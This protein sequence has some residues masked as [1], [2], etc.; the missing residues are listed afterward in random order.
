MAGSLLYL[1]TTR[2]VFLMQQRHYLVATIPWFVKYFCLV[3]LKA[4]LNSVYASECISHDSRKCT[5]ISRRNRE[6]E[7]CG[8]NCPRA[9][10][11]AKPTAALNASSQQ[12]AKHVP[13][14]TASIVAA[15]PGTR[16]ECSNHQVERGQK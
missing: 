3:S 4:F 1:Q 12:R 11:C 13:A 10:P 16:K 14:S 6:R 15:E 2:L 5:Q 9:K 8:P 7:V